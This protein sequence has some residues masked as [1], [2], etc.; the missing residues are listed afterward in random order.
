MLQ[1][2]AQGYDMFLEVLPDEVQNAELTVEEVVSH[3]LLDLFGEGTVDE[4]TIRFS[5]G[6]RMGLHHCSIYIHAQ[7]PCQFFAQLPRTKENI[8]LAVEKSM[9]SLLKE[10][11]GTVHIDN[12]T[13][14]PAPWEFENGSA[15]SRSA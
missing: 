10:L 3:V 6:L 8:K 7:C 15:L 12:V 9:Q 4:V 13:L 2:H 14:I 5:S 1:I 11:F